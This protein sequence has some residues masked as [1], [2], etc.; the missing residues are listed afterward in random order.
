MVKEN[1]DWVAEDNSCWN[2]FCKYFSDS[3]SHRLIENMMLN[4]EA[5][6]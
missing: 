2:S 5:V 1:P 6:Q 3:E 4:S